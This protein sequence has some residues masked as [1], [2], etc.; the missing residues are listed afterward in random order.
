MKPKKKLSKTKRM[1]NAMRSASREIAIAE[2]MNY[3]RK[4]IHKN[5]RKYCRKNL[6]LS[7]D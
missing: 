7:L 4:R 3:S 6:E 1:I 2:N 5:K